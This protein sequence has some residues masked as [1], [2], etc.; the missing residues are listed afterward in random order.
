VEEVMGCTPTDPIYLHIVAG[1]GGFLGGLSMLVYM[2]PSGMSDGF[3]RLVLSTVAGSL[4][5]GVMAEKLFGGKEPELI[6]ASAFLIGFTAWSLLGAVAKFFE[7]RQQDDIL[8]MLKSYNEAKDTRP[9]YYSKPAEPLPRK[10]QI[11]NPDG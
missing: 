5:A 11:D 7:N 8:T 2:R 10:A 1:S 4:L 9:S 6:A 3:R